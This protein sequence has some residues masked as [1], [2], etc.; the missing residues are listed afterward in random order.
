MPQFSVSLPEWFSNAIQYVILMQEC[1]DSIM[2]MKS[3]IAMPG[4]RR[5]F[6]NLVCILCCAFCLH[7]ARAQLSSE[8][9][10]DIGFTELQSMLGGSLPTG[11]G[12]SVTQ[13]EAPA[14]G[15]Y[16]PDTSSFS[17]GVFSFPSGGNTTVSSHA[18]SV[19]TYLYGS[20]S[21]SPSLGAGNSSIAVYEANSWLSS[22]FLQA[23]TASQLPKNETASIQN[24]S[25][26]GTS[27]NATFD[28]QIL[29]RF[30][31]MLDRDNVVATVGLN[32]GNG[33]VPNLMAQS[34]N[35]LVV[36]LSNG[37]HSFGS[38]S[39]DGSGRTKPSLVVPAGATSWAT[40]TVA[41]AAALLLD[42]A[43]TTPSL[44]NGSK[45]VVVRSILLAGASKG[46]EEF[47]TPWNN[48]ESSPLDERYGAG[49]L[50]VAASYRI[51][52]AGEYAAS[53]TSLADSD[54]WNFGSASSQSAAFYFFDLNYTTPLSLTACL[55][56]NSKVT[57]LDTNPSSLAVSY[58]FSTLVSN[59]DLRL[60]SASGFTLGTQIAAS[61]STVD[62][63][64][65]IYATGLSSGRYALSVSSDS[66]AVDYSL[67]WTAAVPEPASW[68]L[69]LLA[70]PLV[71]VFLLPARK[72]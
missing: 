60:Y 13:V 29:R 67:A 12:I 57:P 3:S 8:G 63:V 33:P 16:R 49:E 36:G 37:S 38:T 22:G 47:S 35:A 9:L 5:V 27:S 39:L 62:N 4:S 59:L 56:W 34:H 52:T 65:L 64:E 41:S 58:D 30:D 69:L 28:T 72:V 32:N 70:V 66:N 10:A 51:L 18:T 45:S 68:I 25:W 14:A 17:S 31:Y 26:I 40:P 44:S 23:S 48:S 15:S 61:L 42:K 11:Q 20:G 55:V 53:S 7:Q 24:H 54:G 43:S 71:R 1:Q 21:L 19:G 50:D 46:E 6:F 2:E